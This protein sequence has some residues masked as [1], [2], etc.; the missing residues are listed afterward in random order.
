MIV[1]KVE[2]H[3]A[4]TGRVSTLA[5]LMIVNDGKSP[6]WSRGDYDVWLLSKRGAKYKQGRVVG[7]RRITESVW[8]LV[9]KSLAALGHKV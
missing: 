8:R 7:H 4:I 3:S 2:L 9:L 6:E 1:V 5:Q